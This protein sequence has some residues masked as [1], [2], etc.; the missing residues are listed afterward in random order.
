MDQF[1]ENLNLDP[2]DRK[3]KAVCYTFTKDLMQRTG[4]FGKRLRQTTGD[5]KATIVTAAS[6]VSAR[7]CY[8]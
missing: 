3:P 1:N 7:S 8:E 5:E 6:I 4:H 2:A